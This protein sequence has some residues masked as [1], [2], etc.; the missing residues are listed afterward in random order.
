MPSFTSPSSVVSSE[1]RSGARRADAVTHGVVVVGYG[2]VMRTDDGFGWHAAA[3]L[4]DDP[5][6]AGVEILQRHQLTP[7]LALDISTA[8]LVVLI[9][10]TTGLPPGEFTVERVR[11]SRGTPNSWSHH[12]SPATLVSLSDELYGSAAD[13]VVVSCGVQSL[14]VGDRLSSVAEAACRA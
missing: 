8:A 5:R 9:D 12:L 7:E 10:A 4:A 1:S 11:R 13:V 6:L 14:D 2:N 3:R